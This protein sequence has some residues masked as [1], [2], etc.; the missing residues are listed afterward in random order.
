A[1]M[2][3]A[4]GVA[5]IAEM[6]EAGVT[7]SLGTDCAICNNSSD[8]FLEMRQLGLAQKLE[9]GAETLAA[10]QILR[11]ATGCGAAAL[12]EGGVRGQVSPGMAADLILLDT[13]NLRLQ[14][15]VHRE[16]YS[17]VAA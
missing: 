8:M 12:G 5:R 2:K 3:L 17:N 9:Y 11:T 7:V 15:L 14:P 1:E 16:G 6:V 10:E 13:R 4:D